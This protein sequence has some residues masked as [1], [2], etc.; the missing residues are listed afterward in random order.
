MVSLR[1]R[2]HILAA[3]CDGL[4]ATIVAAAT[5]SVLAPLRVLADPPQFNRDVR[6]ILANH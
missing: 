1:Q 5:L 2:V 6:P 4:R 3:S